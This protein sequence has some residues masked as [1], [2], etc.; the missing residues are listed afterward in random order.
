MEGFERILVA[1]DGS[2]SAMRAVV[3]AAKLACA[4]GGNLTILNILGPI[5]R[6]P[7][8]LFELARQE[9]VNP[10]ALLYDLSEQTLRMAVRMA[11][12][13]GISNV[14]TSCKKGPVAASIIHVTEHDKVDVIVLGKRGRGR[15]SG[16]ILGSVSQTVVCAAPCAT[17][18]VP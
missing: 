4:V 8:E 11:E 13:I 5:D 3:V 6:E 15:V 16:L 14:R 10:E 18:V 17:I 7:E 9:R 12:E 2:D 1:T